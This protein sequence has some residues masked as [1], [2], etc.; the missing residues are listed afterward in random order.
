MNVATA[1]RKA[2]EAQDRLNKAEAK[3]AD[4]ATTRDAALAQA[5]RAGATYAEMEAATDLSNARVTQILRRVRDR[6]T[7]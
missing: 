6:S 5:Q 2:A 4:A 1:L 7:T 3:A